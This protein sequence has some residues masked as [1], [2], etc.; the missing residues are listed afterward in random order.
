VGLRQESTDAEV[1]KMI[2]M[3]PVM[4]GENY[5]IKGQHSDVSA[6]AIREAVASNQPAHG[7]LASTAEYINLNWLYVTPGHHV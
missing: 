7:L 3:L 1:K 5:I 2:A 4:P 6:G